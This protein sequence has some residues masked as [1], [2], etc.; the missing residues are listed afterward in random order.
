MGRL[1]GMVGMNARDTF[2]HLHNPCIRDD[3]AILR[4]VRHEGGWCESV[5][6]EIQ[7]LHFASRV[8]RGRGGGRGWSDPAR[9]RASGRGVEGNAR[10][11]NLFVIRESD[12]LMLLDQVK[13]A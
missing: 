1:D 11:G 9:C 3:D 4:R 10:R 8:A 7:D 12:S 2:L 13:D 6:K 5:V